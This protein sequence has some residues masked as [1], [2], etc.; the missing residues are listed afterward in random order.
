MTAEIV[1]NYVLGRELGRGGM[2]VVYAATHRVLGH[3]AAIKLL[4]PDTS[5]HPAK[6]ERFFNEARAATA[7]DHPGILRVLDV[8]IHDG[9][10]F[11]VMEYLDG[12][13]LAARIANGPMPIRTTIL[14]ATQIAEALAAAHEARIVHRDLKPDNVFVTT[15]ERIKLLD[16]GIAKLVGRDLAVQTASGAVVG[17]PAYMA[18]EQCEGSRDVDHR[19]DLYALGCV[20]YAMLT[21]APPFV[22]AGTGA[23]IGMHLHVEPPPLAVRRPTASPELAS[24]VACLLAKTPSDRFASARAVV[25]ALQ[26]PTVGALDGAAPTADPMPDPTGPTTPAGGP[27]DAPPP[28]APYVDP[29]VKGARPL[30]LRSTVSS[31]RATPSQRIDAETPSGHTPRLAGE[32]VNTPR[33]R[34]RRTIAII[35]IAGAIG[36]VVTLGVVLGG[37]THGDNFTRDGMVAVADLDASRAPGPIPADGSEPARAP[38]NRD[39]GVIDGGHYHYVSVDAVLVV[40]EEDLERDYKGA[41][42]VADCDTLEV[43]LADATNQ[44]MRTNAFAHGWA[45]LEDCLWKTNRYPKRP[46]LANIDVPALVTAGK[47]DDAMTICVRQRTAL[48]VR[49]RATCAIAACRTKHVVWARVFMEIIAR[50][51]DKV[52]A[53]CRRFGLALDPWDAWQ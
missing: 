2:G 45:L 8:G 17:T 23:L 36:A 52:D 7:I 50:D 6:I 12:T 16:F 43:M 41:A 39:A 28:D 3:R 46:E 53:E 37:G 34:T 13:S 27:G 48:P 31:H 51:R 24:I 44:V 26:A 11:I 10:A 14:F 47:N 32:L 49:W 35:G 4:L 9:R 5:H 42:A 40:T 21:G 15:A 38:S 22:A 25:R 29:T 1:G 18:P 20:M 33:R 30:G 19:A